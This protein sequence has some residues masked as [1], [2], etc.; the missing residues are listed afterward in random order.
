MF[1]IIS[2]SGKVLLP[3]SDPTVFTAPW[4]SG[5]KRAITP[6]YH[7]EQGHDLTMDI[8]VSVLCI[9]KSEYGSY[10]KR[11]EGR[12]KIQQGR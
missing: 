5:L 7:H 12:G 2:L 10:S 3:Y 9:K 4:Q 11:M 1:R 6:V 8:W